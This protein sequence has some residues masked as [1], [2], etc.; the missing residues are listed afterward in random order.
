MKKAIAVL[1]KKRGPGRPPTGGRDPLLN[2]RAPAE[3]TKLID[4]WGA[5]Q[6]PSLSRSE[7]IRAL[8]ERGLRLRKS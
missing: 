2:F 7:A 8:I 5:G 4:A 3:L 6:S 1:P